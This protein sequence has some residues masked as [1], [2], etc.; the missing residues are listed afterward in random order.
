MAVATGREHG[1]YING[2][3]VEPASGEANPFGL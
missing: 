1:L 2:E 3:T